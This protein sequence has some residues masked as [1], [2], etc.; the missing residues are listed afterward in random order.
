[1]SID[2]VSTRQGVDIQSKR[3]AHLLSAV[4]A[5]ALKDLMQKPTAQE[6][7]NR[8]NINPNVIRSI[9]FFNSK[10]FVSYANLIGMDA[11]EFMNRAVYGRISGKQIPESDVRIMRARLRWRCSADVPPLPTSEEDVSDEEAWEEES[12][13]KE[14]KKFKKKG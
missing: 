3:C 9:S 7:K 4:I 5:Q 8:I 2:F 14:F 12:M 11:N 1:M 10:T 6:R 13:E